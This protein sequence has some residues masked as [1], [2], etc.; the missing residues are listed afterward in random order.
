MLSSE[1]AGRLALARPDAVEHD[2]HGRPSFRVAGR[3]FAT[4]WDEHHMNVMVDEPG[5]L[6]AVEAHPEVC[7]EV[8]W[9]VQ[10]PFDRRELAAVFCGGFLGAVARTEVAHA[11][12][13]SSGR[14][15][16]ATPSPTYTRGIG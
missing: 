7:E 16:W 1:Q 4:L 2:H 6:T 15:P 13:Y 11:L 9:S 8:R 12:P 5:V 10:M 14:W 3:I